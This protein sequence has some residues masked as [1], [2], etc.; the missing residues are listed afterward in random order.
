MTQ[1]PTVTDYVGRK[2]SPSGEITAVQYVALVAG[3]LIRFA[4]RQCVS[5]TKTAAAWQKEFRAF[6]K[7][8]PTPKR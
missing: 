2:G 7:P 5:D 1:R 4:E 8:S 6:L 3:A